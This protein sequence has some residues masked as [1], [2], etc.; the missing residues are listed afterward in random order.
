MPV[1]HCEEVVSV[2]GDHND[3]LR[4]PDDGREDGSVTSRKKPRTFVEKPDSEVKSS[5]QLREPSRELQFYAVGR[6]V[7]SLK[8]LGI[9]KAALTRT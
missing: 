2:K 8:R 1:I 4:S 3:P 5:H 9:E 6:R 7:H